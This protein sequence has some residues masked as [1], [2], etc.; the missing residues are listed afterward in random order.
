[1]LRPRGPG[2][3]LGQAGRPGRDH[4]QDPA[5][6]MSRPT[7]CPCGPA[8]GQGGRL[9]AVPRPLGLPP[10]QVGV[11]PSVLDPGPGAP[12][13]L[14]HRP[15]ASRASRFCQGSW[16]EAGAIQIRTLVGPSGFILT[17]PQGS[18]AL[19]APETGGPGGVP[20]KHWPAKQVLDVGTGPIISEGAGY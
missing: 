5:E 3:A 15:G 20:C 8:H 6:E 16:S 11:G 2:A 19:P 4:G 13:R 9:H 1:M 7:A 12:L 14:V 18:A 17:S 10:E